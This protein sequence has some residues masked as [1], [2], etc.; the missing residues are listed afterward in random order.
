MTQCSIGISPKYMDFYI[1]PISTS[2]SFSLHNCSENQ[3]P[4]DWCHRAIRENT[5]EPGER[6][7]TKSKSK[8]RLQ[9][10]GIQL[11]EGRYQGIL[12]DKT[13]ETCSLD[14]AGINMNVFYFICAMAQTYHVLIK[15]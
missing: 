4:T 9:S 3:P 11:M 6:H 10:Y 14:N 2:V 8:C 12:V 5:P 1:V 13:R 15:V 7:L